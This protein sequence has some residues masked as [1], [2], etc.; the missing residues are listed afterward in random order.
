VSPVVLRG[1]GRARAAAQCAAAR[2]LPKHS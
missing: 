1:R 2:K